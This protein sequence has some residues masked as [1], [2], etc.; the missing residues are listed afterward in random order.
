MRNELE[1]L[2]NEIESYYG[3]SVTL[4]GG[5]KFF[6]FNDKTSITIYD[7]RIVTVY[8]KKNGALSSWI[9]FMHN[10]VDPSCFQVTSNSIFLFGEFYSVEDNTLRDFFPTI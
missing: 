9:I 7:D 3:P 5:A 2:T 8:Q 10:F 6:P 4:V 1:N